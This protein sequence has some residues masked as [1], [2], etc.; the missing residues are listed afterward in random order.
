MISFSA[1]DPDEAGLDVAGRWKGAPVAKHE[2]P[3]DDSTR[4]KDQQ[5]KEGCWI[6]NHVK[7]LGNKSEEET[8]SYVIAWDKTSTGR[9]MVGSEVES[10]SAQASIEKMSERRV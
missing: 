7:L 2:R 10:Q 4:F 3:M 9:S 6:E 1:T 8:R 5:P